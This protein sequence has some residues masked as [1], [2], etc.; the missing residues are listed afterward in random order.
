MPLGRGR[1]TRGGAAGRRSKREGQGRNGASSTC[2]GLKAAPFR[3]FLVPLQWPVHQQQR[4]ERGLRRRPA[5]SCDAHPARLRSARRAASWRPGARGL[6]SW[7]ASRPPRR[8]PTT[9]RAAPP[10]QTPCR[11]LG[12]PP[13]P[14]TPGG[15]G[16][17]G[18][19]VGP[20][21]TALSSSAGDFLRRVPTPAQRAALSSM[22]YGREEPNR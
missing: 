22:G 9:A 14:H 1:C 8:P 16:G 19:K 21:Y 10:P 7:R 6:G 18:G 20:L 4:G 13:A 5:G 12:W 11:T 2:A 15:G 3:A 17:G